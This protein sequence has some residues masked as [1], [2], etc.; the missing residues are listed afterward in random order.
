MLLSTTS[1]IVSYT[2]HQQT[3]AIFSD[4]VML[5]LEKFI[6]TYQPVLQTP[7]KDGGGGWMDPYQYTYKVETSRVIASASIWWRIA[8]GKAGNYKRQ[9]NS[10]RDNIKEW[11]GQSLSSMGD[12]YCLST[13]TTLGR[14]GTFGN[15]I[16]DKATS[17]R[18]VALL[19]YGKKVSMRH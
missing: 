5:I 16:Y 13:T 18:P 14:H 2:G 9:C 8:S 11:T 1:N 7:P 6:S 3:Q 10:W 19:L 15:A 4:P 17:K 12:H